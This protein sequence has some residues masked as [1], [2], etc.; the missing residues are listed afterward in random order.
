MRPNDTPL[1]LG[2]PTRIREALG[3]TPRIP[4][5]QTID[6]LLDYWRGR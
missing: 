5:D 6:D 3:W 2:D 1:L 4:L